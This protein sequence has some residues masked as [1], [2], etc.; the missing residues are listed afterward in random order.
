MKNK[1]LLYR[2]NIYQKE[3]FPFA[4]L[5]FT[6]L[7]VVLSSSVIVITSD[8]S[9]LNH[10]P[11]IIIGTLTCLLFMFNIRVF[12][13]FKDERFDSRF[14][15]E[16]PVQKGIITLN[17]INFL[18]IAGLSIQILLNV[19]YSLSAFFWW[20][21]AL[22]YSLIAR[23][24]FFM[25]GWI[26][27]RF[28]IYNALNLL[29]IFFLQIYLYKL[30]EPALSWKNNLLFIHFI[31][32]LFNAG[33]LDVA[34]KLKRKEDETE[35]KDTYSSRL[36]METASFMY[37]CVCLIVYGLFLYLLFSLKKSFILFYASL[38]P[39]AVVITSTILYLSWKNK[40]STK[41]VEG[42]AILF[43]LSMHLLLVFTRI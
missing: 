6:T 34:R 26:R 38:I 28:F 14:H 39:L 8:D 31:F 19:F 12:D 43:Y 2:F 41:V 40:A 17:E 33:L 35:G 37:S 1:S 13:D 18:N 10:L 4:I 25:K 5:V 27:K 29:Q 3:R 24:E 21:L 15:K 30:I 7:S 20:L 11:G 36:G 23:M 9:I 42:L 22:A 32:V 16:R